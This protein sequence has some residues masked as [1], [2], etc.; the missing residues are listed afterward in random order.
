MR[1]CPIVELRRYTLHPGKRETLIALFER[2]FIETQEDAGI[3][4]IAQF[5]DI[6]RPDVF[7]WLRGFT[8]MESRAA[9]LA[10]FYDGP[11][12]RAHRDAANDTMI[13][14]DN[15]LLL[16]PTRPASGF[17]FGKADRAGV[18]ASAIPPG[19]FVATIYPLTASAAKDFADV[20]DRAIMPALT[21]S[22]AKPLAVFETEPAK[23]T[24]PRLPVRE[25][26]NVLVSFARFADVR[27]YDRHVAT[28][29]E[30]RGWRE[31]AGPTLDKHLASPVET[32]RL[33]PTAR[34]RLLV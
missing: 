1:C 29:Q 31:T 19:L 16:R 21:A 8:D 3:H 32:L 26:E 11:T 15:V 10:A 14:S 24:F 28:L 33:T 20:F 34:S 5:R 17:V 4:L 23:N 27:A 13:D 22:G 7:T 25:G 12:W 6:D 9:V 2:E 30:S 18:G